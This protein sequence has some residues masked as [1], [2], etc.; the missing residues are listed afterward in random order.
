MSF[1]SGNKM[2]L[3]PI[4]WDSIRAI[5]ALILTTSYC[6]AVFLKDVPVDKISG[7]KELTLLAL[8]FYFVLKRRPQEDNNK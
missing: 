8:T 4:W 6:I 5:V 7:L 3:I 1:G 2:K